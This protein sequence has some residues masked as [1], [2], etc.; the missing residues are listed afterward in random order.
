MQTA[1]HTS[2]VIKSRSKMSS[3]KGLK[4]VFIVG[5]LFLFLIFIVEAIT[6]YWIEKPRTLGKMFGYILDRRDAYL[7]HS[8]LLPIAFYI[9]IFFHTAIG[10]RKYFLRG[11]W[12]IFMAVNIALIL[13]LTYLHFV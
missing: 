5:S 6:G 8:T 9:L 10:L 11:R 13:F 1:P 2:P 4:R 3:G 12:L 7:L